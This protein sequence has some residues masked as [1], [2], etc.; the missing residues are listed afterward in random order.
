ML[1]VG[2]YLAQSV[3]KNYIQYQPLPMEIAI[4]YETF[5]KLRYDKKGNL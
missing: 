4:E 1:K 2:R 5:V 3:R